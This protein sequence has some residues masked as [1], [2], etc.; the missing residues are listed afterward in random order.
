MKSVL[1]FECACI[2]KEMK[3]ARQTLERDVWEKRD[4]ERTLAMALRISQRATSCW[5]EFNKK[6]P[7][8]SL[9]EGN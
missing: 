3:W 4:G 5:N 9:N 1:V 2:S 8:L 6:T 7:V